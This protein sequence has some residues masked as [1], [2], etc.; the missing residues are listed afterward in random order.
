MMRWT[1]EIFSF[2]RRG[3]KIAALPK[4]MGTR[5]ARLIGVIKSSD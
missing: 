1:V 5:L 3:G 2:D 4:D